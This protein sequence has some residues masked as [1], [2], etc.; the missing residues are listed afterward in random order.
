[1]CYP[2]F[3]EQ[4]HVRALSPAAGAFIVLARFSQMYF[5]EMSVTSVTAPSITDVLLLSMSAVAPNEPKAARAISPRESEPERASVTPS[6]IIEPL[7]RLSPYKSLDSCHES[8]PT[9][10]LRSLPTNSSNASLDSMPGPELPV[11]FSEFSIASDKDS[12]DPWS[13]MRDSAVKV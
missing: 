2:H 8:L 10:G 12:Y 9:G 7:V 4:R 11:H 5:A 3:K 1:V 13:R 6:I